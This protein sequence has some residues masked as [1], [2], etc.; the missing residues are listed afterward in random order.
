MK[1]IVSSIIVPRITENTGIKI[2]PIHINNI[3]LHIEK[4]AM[5]R[6]MAFNEYCDLLEPSTPEFESLINAATTNE[7]Y[8]FREKMQFAF[9]RDRVFPAFMG[10]KVVIWSGAC[11][12]G[13]EPVSLYSLATSCGVKPEIHAS[14]IDSNELAAFKK[15][16]YTKYS[17]NR[18]GQ[19]F[20]TLL[21]ETN[22]GKFHDDKFVLNQDIFQS[23]KIH[24]YNL[25]SKVL[26]DFFDQADI[27][28]LRNVFIYFDNELRKQILAKV[29]QKLAPGGLLFLSVGEICCINPEIVPNSLEK[30][31]FD[32]VY[33][34]IKKGGENPLLNNLLIDKEHSLKANSNAITNLINRKI[35]IKTEQ[36]TVAET[37]LKTPPKETA[38]PEET[39]KPS[40]IFDRVNIFLSQRRYKESLQFLEEYLPAF[41]EKFYKEYFLGLVFKDEQNYDE[42][43]K[44][45]SIAETICPNFWPAF[46]NH[47]ILLREQN[48]ENA[49]KRCF[50]KSMACIEKYIDSKNSDFDFLTESFSPEYFYSLCKKYVLGGDEK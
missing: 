50:E 10:K 37:L 31:N 15:G 34:Y 8:F 42:A 17:L 24:K 5:E 20:H 27:I 9:L 29:A 7:T 14:D 23:V 28:F 43:I 16:V 6:N 48:K 33:Y 25:A 11:A 22:T 32:K 41:S 40:E 26:P 49:A 38:K 36:N 4:M 2:S 18:D 47:G 1:D 46:F 35:E 13:E 39:R 3:K 21:E 12:S 19:D 45:F 44:H 30:R